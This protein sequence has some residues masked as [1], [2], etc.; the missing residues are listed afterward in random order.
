MF[1]IMRWGVF[2][3]IV[4][5][6]AVQTQEPPSEP[7]LLKS[8]SS[9]TLSVPDMMSYNAR[10]DGNGHV[11]YRLLRPD[12]SWN[13]SV[14][15]KLDLKSESSTIYEQPADYAGKVVLWEFALTPSG[16]LWYLDELREKAGTTALGFDSN[17]EVTSHTHLDTPPNL[18]VTS[19]AAADDDSLLVG[20]FFT[21]E[22]AP[23]L[24]GKSYLATFGR[25]GTLTKDVGAGLPSQDM[26]AFAK[27]IVTSAP[28]VASVDG[29]FYV[30]NAD[31]VLVMS[32]SGEIIG[33]MKF[34]LPGRE[35]RPYEMALSGG[36]LSIEF[37]IPNAD[38]TLTPEFV[39][40]D[41][42]SGMPYARYRSSEEVGWVCLCFSRQDG[43]TFSRRD[44]G[45]IQLVTAPLR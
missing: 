18:F 6:L 43:Y 34:S 8:S 37:L 13:E 19:F 40:V 1:P 23:E 38:E 31:T 25:T 11:F 3:A 30:L 12:N 29:N 42:A 26:A 27:G 45:K 22:A 35:G 39:V 16:R 9:R 32:Q 7:T 36:L 20:G 41:T 14:V 28:V 24:R 10:C 15:M 5:T 4:F 21:N 44:N 33:R 17:G 2:A